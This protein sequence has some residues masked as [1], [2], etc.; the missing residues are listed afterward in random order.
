MKN[1]P[2]ELIIAPDNYP[3]MKYR[4]RYAYEH[5]VN[6]WK[7][8]GNI[9]AKGMEIHHLNG[10]HRDNRTSNLRLVT[11]IEHKKIH[12]ELKKKPPVKIICDYCKKE[13]LRDQ[14]DHRN[15]INKGQLFFFC[16]QKCGAKK[17]HEFGG[18]L[19]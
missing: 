4:G 17:Q 8:H 14:R 10:N 6:W 16:S 12:G 2:Y 11:S 15:R 13:V 9:L 18:T 5:I 3:G 7:K 19:R 1:G